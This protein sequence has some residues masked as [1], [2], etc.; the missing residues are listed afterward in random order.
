MRWF[1]SDG[2][3]SFALLLRARVTTYCTK[4]N[5]MAAEQWP[6]L[7]CHLQWAQATYLLLKRER[8]KRERDGMIVMAQAH[9]LCCKELEP[10]LTA[11]KGTIQK[12]K[13]QQ[14]QMTKQTTHWQHYNNQLDFTMMLHWINNPWTLENNSPIHMFAPL[15]SFSI[16]NSFVILLSIRSDV[17]WLNQTLTDEQDVVQYQWVL[18]S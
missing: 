16:T 3:S 7:I 15:G 5:K 10:S 6:D 18:L 1:I 8:A 2:S 14:P 9:L 4:G 11:K 12:G 13:G 17:W